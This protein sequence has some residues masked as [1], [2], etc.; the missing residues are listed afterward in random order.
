MSDSDAWLVLDEIDGV[1]V[2]GALEL[3][4]KVAAAVGDVAMQRNA[5]ELYAK[6]LAARVTP[7]RLPNVASDDTL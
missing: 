4:A 3:Q 2:L 6:L 5:E 7:P 1:E